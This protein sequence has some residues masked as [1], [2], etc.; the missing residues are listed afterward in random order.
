MGWGWEG[1]VMLGEEGLRGVTGSECDR[2]QVKRMWPYL[3]G[4]EEAPATAKE[5]EAR[6]ARAAVCIVGSGAAGLVEERVVGI[7]LRGV[8]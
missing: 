4:L 8:P 5:G 2:Y 3:A 6:K 7:L 1:I